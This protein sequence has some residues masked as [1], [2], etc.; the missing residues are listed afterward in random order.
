M[1][2]K[3]IGELLTFERKRR[4]LSLAQLAEQT[5]VNPEKLR[6]LEDNRFELLPSSPFVKGYLRS[7]ARVLSLDSQALIAV[8]RR[9]YKESQGGRL[10]PRAA[11]SAG[12]FSFWQSKIFSWPI[13]SVAAFVLALIFY[14]FAQWYRATRPPQLELLEPKDQ[15]AVAA[16]VLVS[17]YTESD[18][19]LVVNETPVALNPD[20]FFQ[21][22]LNFSDEGLALIKVEAIDEAGR[23]AMLERTVFV[24][25]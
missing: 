10:V 14:G 21:T 7:C 6:A 13:L 20:G 22:T 16:Q 8:L 19:L 15:A 9:D 23:S 1:K 3:T 18:S 24:E 2:S 25:F 4:G 11:E 17:G 12:R 5:Q